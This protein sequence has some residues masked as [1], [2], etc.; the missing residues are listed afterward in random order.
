MSGLCRASGPFVF[1]HTRGVTLHAPLVLMF[2]E[3]LLA[4]PN[5][6]LALQCLGWSGS[7]RDHERLVVQSVSE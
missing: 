1:V 6:D 3:C 4:V 7:F 5:H 2:L